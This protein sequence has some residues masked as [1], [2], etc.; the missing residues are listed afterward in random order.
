MADAIYF[1]VDKTHGDYA[2]IVSDCTTEHAVRWPSNNLG[3]RP[4]IADDEALI[5]VDSANQTWYQAK[6]WDGGAGVLEM[7]SND[8]SGHTAYAS[9]LTL[10]D[11]V[12]VWKIPIE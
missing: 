7:Y 4:N 5:K 10:M 8:V 9:L 3:N 1:R 12:D 11:T 6:A 2:T